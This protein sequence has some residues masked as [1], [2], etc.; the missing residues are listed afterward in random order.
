LRAAER[1]LSLGGSAIGSYG[2]ALAEAA[3]FAARE[4]AS[5]LIVV[6]T[7]SGFMAQHV[8]ALR[9]KQ[10]IIAFTHVLETYRR[11]AAVWGIESYLLPA[12]EISQQ[13]LTL[14]DNM[15]LQLNLA[16][17]GETIV[18]V[19]GSIS[20]APLSNMVKLHRVGE[21]SEQTDSSAS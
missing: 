13:L 5:P 3:V 14:A 20:G 19:A 2:R 17:A 1:E 11:L 12:N 15:L 7:E 18:M 16:Q 6:F 9:P 8:S 10:E 4:V 21:R